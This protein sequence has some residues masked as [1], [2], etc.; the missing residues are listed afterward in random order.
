MS[1]YLRNIFYHTPLFLAKE[2]YNTNKYVND[3][4]EKHINYSL[5]ELKKYIDR[6]KIPKKCKSK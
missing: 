4:I 1:K 6:E 5:I 3:D 2:W